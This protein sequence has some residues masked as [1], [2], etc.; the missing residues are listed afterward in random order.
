MSNL[1]SCL[2]D[3]IL[4]SILNKNCINLKSVDLSGSPYLIT[5]SSLSKL[6]TVC[7]EL[8]QINLSYVP[9]KK[10]SAKILGKNLKNLRQYIWPKILVKKSNE[11]KT[12]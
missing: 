5:I 2:N 4:I 1:H 6:A 12:R 8:E 11:P 7:P 10:D 3:R 9:L